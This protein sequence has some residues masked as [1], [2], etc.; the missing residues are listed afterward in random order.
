MVRSK[1]M[2]S[3]SFFNDEHEEDREQDNRFDNE[4]SGSR[5]YIDNQIHKIINPD[6]SIEGIF[7]SI[8][9][10]NIRN[11]DITSTKEILYQ[12][13]PDQSIVKEKEQLNKYKRCEIVVKVNG[14]ETVCGIKSLAEQCY[15]CQRVACRLHR[16]LVIQP[17][18]LSTELAEAMENAPEEVRK[19]MIKEK[20]ICLNC[21]EQM[22]KQAKRAKLK[23]NFAKVS[24]FL[25]RALTYIFR[26]NF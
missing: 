12:Q 21:L 6:G 7:G 8:T 14:R 16:K 23:S 9:V 1:T 17:A 13:L 15:I 20:Y 10:T 24:G 18:E 25:S 3:N 2:K 26:E 4:N 5:N 22:D 19:R 11:G